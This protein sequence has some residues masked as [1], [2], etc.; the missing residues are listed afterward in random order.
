MIRLSLPKEPYWL[1][2]PHG[3]KVFVRPLTTA[4]YEAARARGWRMA[5]A[6]AA[7]HAD[8]KAAGADITGLPDLSDEDAL[9]G[10]S[11]MLFAQGLARSAI[12]KWEG[13]LDEADQPAEVTDT[14]I[15]ELMQLPRMAEAC[16]ATMPRR[17]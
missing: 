6:I 11:Q 13:V 9:A 17:R 10:L 7:E 8:L 16:S 12:T 14:A 15:A 1:D 4:V 3:V 2:L 5:R